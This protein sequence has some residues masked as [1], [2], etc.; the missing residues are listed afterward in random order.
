M[1]YLSA[2]E[3]RAVE[4]RIVQRRWR[5]RID[6]WLR[7]DKD[8]RVFC[9]REKIGVCALRWWLKRLGARKGAIAGA[10]GGVRAGESLVAPAFAGR[11]V[12][13]ARVLPPVDLRRQP[14][15]VRFY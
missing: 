9:A 13:A 12:G 7:S 2:A 14:L 15:S 5:V 11:G 8:E 3:R 10:A 1:R 6:A 4:S